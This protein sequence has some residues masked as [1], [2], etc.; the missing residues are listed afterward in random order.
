MDCVDL[1]TTIPGSRK[2]EPKAARRG[3]R[4][5]GQKASWDKR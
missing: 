2:A 4:E 5:K 3:R 1:R